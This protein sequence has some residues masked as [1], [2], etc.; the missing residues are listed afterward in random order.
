MTASAG[1]KDDAGKLR[2]D[3]IAPE[4]ERGLAGVLTYGAEKYGS[5]NWAKGLKY[6]RVY[7]AIRRHLLAWQMGEDLDP[8][9]GLPHL[10]HVACEL[11][12]LSTYEA[13]GMGKQWDDLRKLV[14]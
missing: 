7:G 9:T 1:R 13:R 14:D 10:H 6:S 11:M 8:E 5:H 12:F 4:F 3:L 2:L